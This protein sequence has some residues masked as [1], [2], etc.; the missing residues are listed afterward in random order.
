MVTWSRTVTVEAT[1]HDRAAFLAARGIDP[2]DADIDLDPLVAVRAEAWDAVLAH[3]RSEPVEVGGM[4]LG[5]AFA[6][7]AG[8]RVVDVRHA[9]PALGAR[10]ESTYFRLTPEAW[11]HIC[12]VRDGL[13]EDLLIVGWYHSHPNLGAFYSGTDRASQRAF[14]AR[15]WNVGVVID[16][17]RHEIALFLGPESERL[18]T[19]HLVQY[20]ADATEAVAP[21]PAE[22][23]APAAVRADG[24]PPPA[25]PTAPAILPARPPRT[26]AGRIGPMAA[27][28]L[29]GLL[30]AGAVRRLAR[31]RR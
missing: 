2:A 30:A 15:P 28:A 13:G 17:F 8:R 11:D 25:E 12:A 26:L 27:A 16:P 10:Q 7:A 3:V 1:P 18:T 4:L 9:I 6:D 21:E 14:F 5:E 20:G 31:G 29:L 23:A 19:E 22:A 24:G